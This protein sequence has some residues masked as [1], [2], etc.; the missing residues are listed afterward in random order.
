MGLT[1]LGAVLCLN[2]CA[3]ITFELSPYAPRDVDLVYSQQEDLTFMVWRLAGDSDADLV[4]F[5][6]W[7]AGRYQRIDLQRAPYAAAPYPCANELCFQFQVDGRYVL[8]PGRQ[9]ALRSHHADEGTFTG[10]DV[11][12]VDVVTTIR[13]SPMALGHNTTLDP[14]L[15]DWFADNRVPLRRGFLVNTYLFPEGRIDTA[16]GGCPE[17]PA[18]GWAPLTGT[19]PLTDDWKTAPRCLALKPHRKLGETVTLHAAVIPS[20]ELRSEVQSYVPQRL[21]APILYLMLLDLLITSPERCARVR[22]QLP[23]MIQEAFGQRGAARRIGIYLPVSTTSGETIS[24]CGQSDQQAYPI[25]QILYDIDRARADLND[26]V[27]R[28]I[29]VF[30]NNAFVSPSGAVVAQ[31]ELLQNGVWEDERGY[32]WTMLNGE[33]NEFLIA[34]ESLGWRAIEDPTF[35]GDIESFARNTLPFVTMAHDYRTNVELTLPLDARTEPTY[36]KLCRSQPVPYLRVGSAVDNAWYS[37]ADAYSL[38]PSFGLPVYNIDLGEQDL[39]PNATYATSPT[40]AVLEI[41]EDFC[42]HPFRDSN[43]V[44]HRNWLA[45]KDEFPMEVCQWTP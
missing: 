12:L 5:D 17:A 37:A 41:C 31:L 30:A 22:A 35:K 10:P 24:D 7:Q 32:L 4:T 20:A 39:V 13:I 40:L 38:W 14:T 23:A 29:W 28:V 8:P 27:T 1:L 18:G 26:K 9:S 3:N 33:L 6:L 11:A 36:F 19:M 15:S 42:A 43:E 21:E 16:L 44:D 2:A 25:A 45:T 34:D